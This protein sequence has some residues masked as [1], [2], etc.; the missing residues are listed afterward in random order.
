MPEQ[1]LTR[2]TLNFFSGKY[3]KGFFSFQLAPGHFFYFDLQ[4]ILSLSV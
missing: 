1:A 2:Y 4:Q 3:L